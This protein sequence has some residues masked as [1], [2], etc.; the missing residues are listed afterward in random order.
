VRQRQYVAYYRVSTQRQG[1]SGLGLEAQRESVARYVERVSGKLVAEFKEATSGLKRNRPQ[2]AEAIRIC[3]MRRAVLVIARLDR[4]ARNVAMIADL[5]DSELEFVAVDFPVAS[6]L[7]LHVLAT[8]AEYESRLISERTKAALAVVKARGIKLGSRRPATGFADPTAAVAASVKTRKGKALARAMDLG[9][10]IWEMF[11]KGKPHDE[12]ARELNRQGINTP[13]DAKWEGE[14]VRRVMRLTEKA[15]PLLVKA[16]TARPDWRKVRAGERAKELGPLVWSLR[17]D[18]FSLT[19]I[20]EE[21]KRRAVPTPRGGKWQ[22]SSVHRLLSA[23][24]ATVPDAGTIIKANR[25]GRRAAHARQRALDLAPLVEELRGKG[26]TL[27]AIAAEFNKRGIRSGRGKPWCC[28]SVR[29]I[30]VLAA[31]AKAEQTGVRPRKPFRTPPLDPRGR[32]PWRS[33]QGFGNSRCSA[34]PL[35][36]SPRR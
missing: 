17:R 2:L 32:A 22:T 21:M 36:Q 24:K 23:T 34:S 14:G 27:R 9:P 35:P 4:L 29:Q 15:F 3:R 7:T 1:H 19:S 30:L 31:K 12:I 13:R 20:A 8:I 33:R 25:I 6:R 16:A 26:K 10:L 11:A 18:G 5:M 28:T